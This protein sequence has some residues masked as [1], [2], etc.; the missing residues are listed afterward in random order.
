MASM[1][2]KR[3][4]SLAEDIRAENVAVK[5][6]NPAAEALAA[7]VANQKPNPWSK[8]ML[9]LYSIMAIGYLVSTMN[10]FGKLLPVSR[11]SIVPS[12]S[13]KGRLRCPQLTPN[14]TVRSWEP[15]TQ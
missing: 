15:L 13:W 10:G 12:A 6:V 4:G 3:S 14:K 5:D 11:I 2:K 8:N 9:Q 1:E 7:A